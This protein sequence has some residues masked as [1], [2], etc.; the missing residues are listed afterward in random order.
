MHDPHVVECDTDTQDMEF[1]LSSFPFL[2]FYA[3]IFL[4]TADLQIHLPWIVHI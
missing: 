3:I 1:F 2:K 4:K